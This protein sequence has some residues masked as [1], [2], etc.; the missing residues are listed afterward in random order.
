MTLRI[1]LKSLHP[2]LNANNGHLSWRPFS[3]VKGP[4]ALKKAIWNTI[5]AEVTF[6]EQ[7]KLSKE[8]F[9]VFGMTCAAC[10]AAVERS[11]KK[12]DGV[13]SVSVSLLS[14]TMNVE[15]DG[16]KTDAKA[17][18]QAVSSAGYQASLQNETLNES[19]PDA[20]R[21]AWEKRKERT[22]KEIKEK[23]N[24]LIASIVLLL[25][26]MCFS[27]LPMMGI[28]SFF[29]DMEW[30]MVSS[31]MQ[32]VLCMIILFLQRHFFVHGFKALLKRNPN[33]DSLVAVGS[34]VS[35]LYGMYG[36]LRMA[37]GYGIMDHAIIHSSM[38]ALYFESAAM[39]VTLVSLGKFLE[40]KSKQKTGDALGKL[41]DLA[42][43]TALV[44]KNGTVIE[45]NASQV[46]SGD[47]VVIKPGMRIPVDGIVSEGTGYVDQA[48]IT[49]ES[50]PV[51]KNPG[52][53]VIS[54]SMN[55]NGSF[56]FEAT[57][58]GENTT[59][60]QIIRLVEEAGNSKAPIARLADKVAGVF[61][62]VVMGI[63]LVVLVV[64]LLLGKDLAF[65]LNCAV[66]VLVISCP[67][68]LG[69]ATPLAI[70]VS[71]GKAAE[72]GIL[73]KSAQSLEMLSSIN[74]IVM[75]K[76]GTITN[77]KPVVVQIQ[78]FESGLEPMDLLKIAAAAEMGS[79]HPLG[80]AVVEEAKAKNLSVPAASFFEAVGGRGLR[81][82]VDS[83]R[84]TAGNLAFMKEE[85][86][87]VGKD[88]EDMLHQAA[89]S[90]QTPLLF[91]LDGKLAGMIG[92]ADTI[93]DTSRQ[94]IALMKKQGLQTVMLTGD[95][96]KTA[97][98]IASQLAVDQ[99]IA[100]V[101]PADKE[102]VIAGL[103]K[104]GHKVAM[105]G[106]GI[107]DAPALARADVGI[108]VRAGTDIAIDSADL[109]LMKDNLLD[110]VTA[111]DLSHATLKNIKENLFWA[112]FYNC[113]GI[114][115][116]AGVFYPIFGWLLSPMFGAAAMSISSVSVCL[117][118]LRLRLFKPKGMDEKEIA[119][120]E[121]SHA[122][123]V[124]A[125]KELE[126]ADEILEQ[127]EVQEE[128][129][130]VLLHIDGM[131]CSH[132]TGRVSEA[133]MNVP[134]VGDVQ[135]NLE[136][137]TAFVLCSNKPDIPA[138]EKAVEEA[139][140][141]IRKDEPVTMDFMVEGMS[142]SHCS[143]RVEQALMSIEGVQSAHADYETGKTE[144]TA[145]HPIDFSV[146]EQAVKDAGFSI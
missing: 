64:W 99:V 34:S 81:A 36:L 52:D 20:Q 105:V 136:E 109:V 83:Q 117:N 93:R 19:Q 88:Q 3:F 39:I 127:Q 61:V 44:E 8:T 54:A 30:M 122:Q 14:N 17:I 100:N 46:I 40:A 12:V 78:S 91:A 27:M 26:L 49:G 33:M 98:A 120:Q 45:I 86:I 55:V 146:I 121:V 72:Y 128:K 103:Q 66:C 124:S 87:P 92:V 119:S 115:L 70:M 29:M 101:M 89:M 32:L 106:D 24:T 67:C 133:L 82:V 23:K 42:P 135:M 79:E 73:I 31:I 116:A 141:S 137:G 94:A 77:G 16:Q 48:A 95:N 110:V 68:A 130:S 84:V 1:G 35:F 90:G 96:E 53:P 80:Q 59:L 102:S 57:K 18:E 63:A 11:V 51:E 5:D 13:Q 47:T 50:I 74:T 132:C 131:T 75:D 28:F 140:Y 107:N 62:P 76:T 71:T 43:K 143:G 9:D 125:H 60:S 138:L 142:C 65:A 41:A 118:A 22:E 56:K 10:Q 97:Q 126:N 69:L 25:I 21:Q 37:Y 139:G 114:P 4:S 134:G 145:S 85:N 58:V 112:F 15:Y 38:D 104:E 108:A 111:I 6:M 7:E 113:L 123:I 129:H 2:I 144:I